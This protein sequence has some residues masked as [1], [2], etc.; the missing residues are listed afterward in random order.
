MARRRAPTSIRA[1]NKGTQE[2]RGINFLDDVFSREAVLTPKL[3][4]TRGNL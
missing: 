4:R 1:R 3:K 2:A